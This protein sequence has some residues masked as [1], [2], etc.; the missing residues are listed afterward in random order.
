MCEIAEGLGFASDICGY[1][2][3]S[4]AYASGAEADERPMPQL[5]FLLCCNNICNCMIKWYENIARMHNIQLIM[6]DVPYNNETEVS[7]EVVR[8]LLAQFDEAIA[9]LEKI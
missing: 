6:I 7:D 5:D 2:R 3:I 1:A 9:S 4:L 8:Y